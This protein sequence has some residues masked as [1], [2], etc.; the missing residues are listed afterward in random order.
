[1]PDWKQ[2]A[3]ANKLPLND[4]EFERASTSLTNIWKLFEPLARTLGP[5]DDPSPKFDATP[6]AAAVQKE[7]KP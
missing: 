1:M 3:A 2:L 4:A 7:A 5:M 6:A